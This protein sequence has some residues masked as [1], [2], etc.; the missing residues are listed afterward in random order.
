LACCGG[1]KSRSSLP[2]EMMPWEML[3][4]QTAARKAVSA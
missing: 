4:F 1:W 3:V 2:S